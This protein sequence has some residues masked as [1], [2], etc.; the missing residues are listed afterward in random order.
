MPST[1]LVT[2]RPGVREGASRC[3]ESRELSLR[4]ACRLLAAAALLALVALVGGCGGSGVPAGRAPVGVEGPMNLTFFVTSDTHFTG[5]GCPLP[6]RAAIQAMNSHVVGIPNPAEGGAPVQQAAFAVTLGDLT[7]GGTLLH[8]A[9]DSTGHARNYPDE[10]AGFSACFTR[11]GVPG[12]ANKLSL[13]DYTTVGNHD[14]Y[15]C[16]GTPL[17]GGNSTFVASHDG[18]R[19]HASV[20][21]SDGNVA[22]SFDVNGVHIAMLGRWADPIVRTWLAADLAA[23]GTSTYVVLCLHYPVDPSDGAHLN[24]G[25]EAW[26][27]TGDR[28]ALGAV[29]AGYNIVAILNGHTHHANSYKWTPSHAS[30]APSYTYDCLDDGS[31]GKVGDFGVIHITPSQLTYAQYLTTFDDNGNWTGGGFTKVQLSKSL[32]PQG[33]SRAKR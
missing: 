7:D 13:P 5:T 4:R 11:D 29:I 25:V 21:S 10:W 8:H 28:N 2:G 14:F 30:G 12:D 17:L 19:E 33:L 31:A 27:Q 9:N 15:R 16:D 20:V 6:A 22:Y 18:Q 24:G 23:V 3:R 1:T 26:Y 32:A